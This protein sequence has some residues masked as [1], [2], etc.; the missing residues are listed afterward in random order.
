M[1]NIIVKKSLKTANCF[2]YL[3]PK[4]FCPIRKKFRMYISVHIVYNEPNHA[5]IMCIIS[6]LVC[7]NKTQLPAKT[8]HSISVKNCSKIM[9]T[10]RGI[11][12]CIFYLISRSLLA[13]SNQS[14][15]TKV[16]NI[17][18]ALHNELFLKN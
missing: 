14:A 12:V 5:S 16:L 2:A 18:S 3:C 13:F 10:F 8:P 15:K 6:E 9:L 4:G 7:F 1:K 11:F 17:Q